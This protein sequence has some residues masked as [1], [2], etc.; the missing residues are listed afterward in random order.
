MHYYLT[1]KYPQWFFAR[2]LYGRF[3]RQ[4]NQSQLLLQVAL[5]TPNNGILR[6]NEII[7]ERL[8]ITS[9]A[10]IAE[11]T[12]HR[13][14]DFEK[15]QNI[16][17]FMHHYIG[18][19]LILTEGDKHKFLRKN[20][21]S[22]FHFRHIKNLYPMMWKK[23]LDFADEL[24][25][26]IRRQPGGTS[27]KADINAWASKITFDLIGIA[28][29]GRDF[30]FL[31]NH[32]DRLGQ[33]YEALM[34]PDMLLYTV[35]SIWLSFQFVQ[36]LPWSKNSF[37]REKT[38]SLKQQCLRLIQDKRQSIANDPDSHVDILSLLVKTDNFSDVDLTD[39][40]L[41]FLVAGSV[42]HDT[43]SASLSWALYLLSLHQHWQGLLRTEV[44]AALDAST[45][46]EQDIASILEGL[47]VLNGV[48]NETLRLFPAVPVTA[49]VACRDI[50]LQDQSIPKGT[51][52]LLSPWLINR[53]REVWGQSA[54]VFEPKRWI[55]E[56]TQRPNNTGGRSSN[57]DFMT[58]LHGPRSCIGHGFARAELRC[59]LASMAYRY[60]W[61]LDMDPLDVVPAG[62]VA[63]QPK[64]GL[65]LN[66]SIV[67]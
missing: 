35:M 15:P 57:Y 4:A 11:V 63:I 64:N 46:G 26:N 10:L 47:P 37:F 25:C 21:L 42:R 8:L 27:G 5:D 51:E 49:R 1:A 40:L 52:I 28:G 61:T 44:R 14:Y 62:A 38:L 45:G 16:R 33:D 24:E 9:T 31:R 13:A 29:L 54:D 20:S 60:S 36:L 34:G 66:L 22:S 12:V 2:L 59:L 58:F 17:Q 56:E 3:V 32:D 41:T 7:Q 30:N 55:D 6:L 50:V 53:S 18:D 23:S 65:H 19:G 43:T 48:L 39:Q 67:E